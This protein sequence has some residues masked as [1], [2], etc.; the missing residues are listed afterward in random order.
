MDVPLEDGA[1][2]FFAAGSV[3]FTLGAGVDLGVV[4]RYGRREQDGPVSDVSSLWW[5]C[6]SRRTT[7]TA[8][9]A[10]EVRKLVSS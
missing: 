9:D 1:V 6:C 3:V 5:H 4:V 7:R 8:G 10:G 2:S